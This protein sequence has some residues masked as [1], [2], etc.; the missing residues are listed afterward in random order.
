[1]LKIHCST[2][3][4]IC[5]HLPPRVRL[6]LYSPFCTPDRYK[7][8]C[9]KKTASDRTCHCKKGKIKKKWLISHKASSR[10]LSNS[11]ADTQL[12]EFNS[13]AYVECHHSLTDPCTVRKKTLQLWK[14]GSMFK[15]SIFSNSSWFPWF[16]ESLWC[17]P[18][19]T[20]AFQHSEKEVQNSPG[21]SGDQ[22]VQSAVWDLC[23]R[24][25]FNNI[26]ENIKIYKN[27]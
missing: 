2:N 20:W 16:T 6:K 13:E 10:S 23:S 14:A 4:V 24:E 8:H 17:F 18:L 1:M 12:L 26:I 21:Q 9:T 25:W 11:F 27:I 19:R 22:T 5:I 3:P 15:T 7:L